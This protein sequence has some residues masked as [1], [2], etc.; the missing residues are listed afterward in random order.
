MGQRLEQLDDVRIIA[1]SPAKTDKLAV[2][3][4]SAPQSII[5]RQA[6]AV[7][8]SA[9]DRVGWNFRPSAIPIPLANII[10][11]GQFG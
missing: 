2:V 1:R 9:V 4:N 5:I 10:V 6:D 11:E 8:W 3:Y 7:D